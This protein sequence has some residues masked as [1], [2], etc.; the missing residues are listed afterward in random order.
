MKLINV[1]SCSAVL[2]GAVAAAASAQPSTRA[3]PLRVSLVAAQASS[4]GFL[5][6]VD[7]TIT[8]TSNHTVRVPKWELP[9]DF[10]EAKLFQ[11]SRDGQPVQYQGPMIKRGLPNAADFAI[12]RAGET[13]R[14][15]VDLSGSYD[16]SKSGEYV[17]T[18]ASPLQHASLSNGEMLKNANGVPMAIRS[19]PLRLWVDGSDMLEAKAPTAGKGKP[20]GGGS[21]GTV[22]NGVSYV[23]CSNTQIN[24]AGQ[25]VVEAR[26]YA[27]NGKGYLAGSAGPRY[28]TWF[29]AYTS[30]RW[31]TAGQHFAAIDS[32]IDQ[33]AG[34]VKI[35]CGCNQSYYA[36]V[37][38]TRPYEIFVCRAF[39]NAP[40]TG[41][42][43]KAGTLIHE[44]SHF[45]VV[46]GT[47]DHVYGQSGA[48]SLAISD[49]AS[50]LDNADNHEYFAENNPF[51]N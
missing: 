50:A 43:S 6:S 1:V 8:N 18:L 24:G 21:G 42:D 13:L 5:G 26:K 45:N 30:S 2:A 20:G 34:Q 33:N 27:E 47:D 10:L 39:W 14:T 49:P 40:L 3:N 37:Y 23:G 19:V 7:V 36:Y 29:G 15:T 16:M 51:Q 44:M 28:T 32:A 48:K 22:V 31:S 46:A 41:T 11:V 17:V 35:N 38:P 25:A 4:G 9:S 12:L